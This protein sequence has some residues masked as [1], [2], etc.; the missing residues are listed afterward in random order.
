[1][2]RKGVLLVFDDSFS[3]TLAAIDDLLEVLEPGENLDLVLVL[4]VS[5]PPSSSWVRAFKFSTDLGVLRPLTVSAQDLLE[6]DELMEEVDPKG[7]GTPLIVLV[8]ST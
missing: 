6:L 3:F 7:G 5:Q 1:M 8:A 2:A 4:T